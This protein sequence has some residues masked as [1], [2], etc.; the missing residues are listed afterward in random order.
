MYRLP[1][2]NPRIEL[3][4]VV[5]PVKV[6]GNMD[7]VSS[8][9]RMG[10]ALTAAAATFVFS[11]LLS[12]QSPSPS[13]SSTT[14][15][16]IEIKSSVE[17]GY[18]GLSV[19]GDHEKYRS[20]LNYRAGVRLFDSSLFI[21]NSSS[22]NKLFDEALFQVSGWGS[23]PTGSLRLNM[24]KTGE[25]KI[26]SNV[27]KVIYFNNLKNH[28]LNWSQVSPLA[29][30]HQANTTHYFGDV[31]TTIFPERDFRIRLGYSF[32]DMDGPG[33]TN[34][35]F[36]EE[37]QVKSEMDTHSDD[38]RL[39]V[40]GKL[41]GFNV[42]LN[43][44]HRWFTDR[45]RFFNDVLNIGNNPTDTG[46]INTSVRRFRVDGD[47]DYIQAFIQRTFAKRLDF[48]SRIIYSQ[49]KSEIKE[50]D[51]LNGR[52]TNGNLV[53]SDDI[54]ILG[55]AKRPQTRVDIGVT[56]YA[57]QRF[58]ISNTFSF[59]QFNTGGSN[60]LFELVQATTF[61]GVPVANVTT[62]TSSWRATSYRR[63]SNL[64]EADFQVNRQFAFNIGYRFTHRR[65]FAGR[66]IELNLRNNPPTQNA[67]G[68]KP[69]E[70]LEN[71]THSF[72]AGGRFK[73][74][75]NWSIYA[76]VEKG[77]ADNVFT[78]LANNDFLN[79]R[80]RSVA[81]IKNFAF[82]VSFVTKDNDDNGTSVPVTT[83]S[84]NPPVT[85][86]WVPAF[87]SVAK[88]RSRIFSSSI[89]WTP[90]PDLTI[91][92]GY[93]YNYLTATTD[94]IVPVSTPVLSGTNWFV[95]LSQYFIRDNFFHVDISAR[96]TDRVSFYG[97]YRFNNDDGQGSRSVTRVQDFIT[98]Y[99]MR[100]HSPEFRVAVKLADWVD[101]NVGYQYYSY[102]ETPFFNPFASTNNSVLIPQIIRAQNYNAHLPYTSLRFYFGRS[103]DR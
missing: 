14:P 69:G 87:D 32:S 52:S 83:T 44:G 102:R 79:F 48:T 25:Y 65:A 19:N 55:E 51:L 89:D 101:W 4:P 84:G 31:D 29:S 8:K 81:N 59:D 97:S 3:E 77:K 95:G 99:P 21:E 34:I 90:R 22:G 58:R 94:I 35:R 49:A 7:K 80:V 5:I 71:S 63:Y 54:E 50:T 9:K 76:D 75:Q 16:N 57:P 6:G 45:T 23:D 24:S 42:G 37:F 27:R 85:T 62:N 12:A 61:A 20:D 68:T 15:G 60:E 67:N 98:S 92:G 46:I 33:T 78:R 41:L 88:T 26:D 1:F 100:S 73:P 11:S 70:L 72:I 36:G 56:Y 103:E 40:E 96:P 86:V 17:I 30:E 74:T 2:G 38:V 13:P 53:T 28:A 43:Y 91:T 64:I 82:N 18:R 39:G 93:T 66:A 47:T 10:R